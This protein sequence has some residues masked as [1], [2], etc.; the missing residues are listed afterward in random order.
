MRRRAGFTLIEIAV[1]LLILSMLLGTTVT[2]MQGMMPESATEAAAREILG[3]MDLART[4]AV[5][6]GYPF[7]VLFDLDEQRYAIR[8]PFDED[9]APTQ[10][11]AR[12]VMMTWHT[13]REGAVL[14]GILDPSSPRQER[15]ERG[16]YVLTYHPAGESADF[17][18]YL[19]HEAGEQYRVTIRVLAL[20]GLASL[21]DGEVRP[22]TVTENDF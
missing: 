22:E 20:T 1:V 13:V 17:W 19:G 7:E 8:T 15:V 14:E 2:N 9:G 21:L 5:A 3:T 4:Q 10:D 18:A 16:T 12:R 11:P 6:R